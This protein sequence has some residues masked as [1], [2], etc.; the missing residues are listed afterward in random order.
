MS[1]DRNS[2]SV[3]AIGNDEGYARVFERQPEAFAQKG[4][5][6]FALSTSGN[7]ENV[8]RGIEVAMERGCCVIG[9]TGRREGEVGSAPS[10][11][12]LTSQKRGAL[13]ESRRPA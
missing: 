11:T 10:T 12:V 4:D 3:T 5:V 6:V 9:M 13:A 1:L 2:S 7:S 8:M